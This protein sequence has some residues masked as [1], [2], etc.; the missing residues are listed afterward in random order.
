MSIFNIP[1]PPTKANSPP[2]A[3]EYHI[4]YT[5]SQDPVSDKWL[6]VDPQYLSE[7]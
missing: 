6:Y 2:K 7:A 5:D 1:R 3:Q 4:D